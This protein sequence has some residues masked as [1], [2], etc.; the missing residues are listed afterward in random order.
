MII[1][2]SST[3]YNQRCTFSFDTCNWNIG[4]RWQIKNLDE[5]L[6]DKGLINFE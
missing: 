3:K 5:N 4:R 2:V 1:F 6:D